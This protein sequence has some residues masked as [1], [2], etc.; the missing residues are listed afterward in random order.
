VRRPDLEATVASLALEVVALRARV[1]E[2][3]AGRPQIVRLGGTASA[4]DD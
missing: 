2:L 4:A 3:E 1:A